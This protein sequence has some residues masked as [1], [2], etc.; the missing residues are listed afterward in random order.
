M[1]KISHYKSIALAVFVFGS[2]TVFPYNVNPTCTPSTANATCASSPWFFS[3]EAVYL[4][5]SLTGSDE[6]I[7]TSINA[8]RTLTLFH[9]VP[10]NWSWGYSLVGGYNFGVGNDLTLSWLH[11]KSKGT[12]SYNENIQLSSGGDFEIGAPYIEYVPKLDSINLDLGQKANLGSNVGI[13]FHNGLGYG[14]MH[15]FTEVIARNPLS[16]AIPI[17]QSYTFNFS[18]VSVRAGVDLSYDFKNGLTAYAH[19]TTSLYV[20]HLTYV[21]FISATSNEKA[22]SGVQS[23]VTV[24]PGIDGV[25]GTSY[26]QQT[27]Y[28]R[29]GVN[30]YWMWSRAIIGVNFSLQ[31]AGMGLSWLGDL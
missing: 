8:A 28:G 5:T 21:S 18:A 7:G 20:G 24:A 25:L 1:M 10:Q 2:S 31:G 4:I 13:R 14:R 3:G 11:I 19:G 16:D 30:A 17:Y 9:P 27:S 29:F 6:F 15:S 12:H 22:A 26:S 23:V